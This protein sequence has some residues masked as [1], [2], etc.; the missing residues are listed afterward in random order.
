MDL[1]EPKVHQAFHFYAEA[2][3]CRERL[4]SADELSPREVT[5]QIGQKPS[6]SGAALSREKKECGAIRWP[7]FCSAQAGVEPNGKSRW[8]SDECVGEK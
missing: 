5:A 1:T 4:V 7:T 3:V 8:R 2:R 6:R